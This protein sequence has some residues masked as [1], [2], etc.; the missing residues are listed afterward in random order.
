MKNLRKFK[1]GGV[2]LLA[3]IMVITYIPIFGSDTAYASDDKYVER[4]EVVDVLSDEQ[5][6]AEK[7][8][9]E[10]NALA[11]MGVSADAVSEADVFDEAELLSER[12]EP[13]MSGDMDASPDIADQRSKSDALTGNIAADDG[14]PEFDENASEN[15]GEL[16][17]EGVQLPDEANVTITKFDIYTN[18]D[19]DIEAEIDE[20]GWTFSRLCMDGAYDDII[21]ADIDGSSSFEATFNLK[22]YDIGYHT[23]ILRFCYN[24]Q[25][26]DGYYYWTK[27]ERPLYDETPSIQYDDFTTGSNYFKYYNRGNY[28]SEDDDCGVSIEYKKGNGSWQQGPAPVE[29]YYE[30]KKSGLSEAASY[31][32]RA[33]FCKEVEYDYDGE[34][35]LFKG[36][37]SNALTIKTA[38]KKPKVKSV[39]ISKVKVKCHKYRYWTGKIRERWLVNARTGAKI[40]LV[41]RWK[42]YRTV[43]SYTTRYKVTV[44]FKKKQGIA[45]IQLHTSHGST[46][47]LGG[48]KKSYSKTFTVSGKKKG[49]KLRVSVKTLMSKKYDS[50]SGTYKKK[51]KIR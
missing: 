14:Y 45:G 21:D 9:A 23:L 41:G 11:E 2:L 7:D 29:P 39:K 24:G 38:Y 28:Y 36:P 4:E 12:T 22:D 50:W 48:N 26:V 27:I 42:I 16:N 10:A 33:S 1:R 40:R 49:K 6:A 37:A 46:V 30:S 35:Y 3:A 44:K 5:K 51:V 19:V 25:E 31:S 18:G 32:V 20:S 15:Y 13:Q 47:W 34:T 8:K 17:P 43:R